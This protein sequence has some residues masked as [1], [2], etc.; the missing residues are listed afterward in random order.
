METPRVLILTRS[1]FYR[2]L[3]ADVV[4]CND[5]RPV[6]P[7]GGFVEQ[8]DAQAGHN[9]VV[10]VDFEHAEAGEGIEAVEHLSALPRRTR[11]RIVVLVDDEHGSEVSETKAMHGA[12]TLRG[13]IDV[14]DFARIVARH[15]QEAVLA[16][17]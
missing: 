14:G 10:V 12:A 11:P 13:P 4:A 1:A 7:R 9:D 2:R 8:V 15:A 5:M 17:S 6:T 3:M 16:S